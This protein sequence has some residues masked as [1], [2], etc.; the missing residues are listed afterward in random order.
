VSGLAVAKSNADLSSDQMVAQDSIAS[1]TTGF[2]R[3]SAPI[4]GIVKR[5][6]NLPLLATG[7]KRLQGG[8]KPVDGIKHRLAVQF[9]SFYYTDDR[10]KGKE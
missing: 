2:P 6:A 9:E 10:C 3:F 1:A 7:W 4:S 5:E 8:Y